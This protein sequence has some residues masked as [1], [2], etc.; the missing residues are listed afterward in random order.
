MTALQARRFPSQLVPLLCC[1]GLV[2]PSLTACRPMVAIGAEPS[3]TVAAP[4]PAVA[5]TSLPSRTPAPAATPTSTEAPAL[6]EA[7]AL[8]AAPATVTA[9][10]IP[11]SPSPLPSAT[12]LPALQPTPDEA[13]AGRAV[14]LPI[15]MYH[16]VEPWPVDAD[17][18]RQGLT[19]QPEAFAAQAAYLHGRGYV[20]L[21]LYD[22]LEAVTL[23]R[24]LPE[25]AVVLTFDDGYR[26]L[27]DYALPVMRANGYTGT[28]F[29]LTQLMD[30]EF[31]Q[32]LT[33]AQAEAL[34]AH[35]WKIEP[36]TK[37]HANLMGRGR[38][39]QLYQMLG[40]MQTVA[41]HIGSM[42]R[43]L[44]YP[45]G[46]YDDLSVQLAQEMHLWGAVTADFGRV[47][48]Y[49][50]RYTWRRVRISGQM[51]LA[52]FAAALEGDLLP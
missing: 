46:K 13:A 41:A 23:G 14:R 37:T 26:T 34:Y 43:F 7:G 22:L 9:S 8:T 47:H 12:S 15:L 2:A 27:M 50:G 30:E 5:A 11:P 52:D 31:P 48:T 21:S 38:D 45:S 10:A 42:P 51:T 18:L 19:V 17:E 49:A 33:W 36:H 40:A 29:V 28:V 25:R 35:G 32:Y 16:Y 20:T 1:L 24:P 44:A 6:V 4:A 39:F 3:A